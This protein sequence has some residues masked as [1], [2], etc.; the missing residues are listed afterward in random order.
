M[1]SPSATRRPEAV[2]AARACSSPSRDDPVEQR[3][4]RLEEL[5][6][7]ARARVV[8]DRRDSG[9]SA[10]RRG[11]RTSSRCTRAARASAARRARAPVNAGA[12]GRR[13]ARRSASR[14]SRAARERQQRPALA[15]GVELRGAAPARRGSRRRASA[16]RVGVEQLGRRRRRRATRRARGRSAC[17]YSGAIRT[18]VCCRE[19]VAPPIEQRQL[20]PAPL[21]LLR[22]DDHLVERRR[23]QPGEPDDVAVLLDRGVEDRVARDHDAEVDHL[24]VV[25]AEHDADDV[26]ADVVD[27]ALDG[28]EH[29]ACPA[30]RVVAAAPSRPP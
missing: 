15:L 3:V 5:A 20:E 22:D 4:R 18:A 13:R 6:R 28:R 27:V 9:P 11:R 1:S 7:A 2:D 14:F 21:H 8:E 23:D 25:A 16:R 29:D 26:L 24:V 10:P 17:V 19:V 30:R 12:R